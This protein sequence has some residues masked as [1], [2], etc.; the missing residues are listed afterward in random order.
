MATQDDDAAIPVISDLVTLIVTTSPTPSAP[1]TDLISDILGSFRL[2][3]P[4]LL[5]CR[6][7]VVFDTYDRIG[8]CMRLKKGQVT[9]EG[10]EAVEQ[11]KANVKDLVLGAWYPET[12][13]A[14][15][16]F[17]GAQS[18]AEYGSPRLGDNHVAL[19]TRRTADGRVTF[20][21]PAARLGFG[22][23]VRSAL[24]AAETPY[25]W[26]QQHDW[27]LVRDIPLR[28][29]VGVM[30]ASEDDGDAPPVRY[31]CL[32]AV[33]MLSYATSAH[34]MP[35][36]ALRALTE[37][38]KGDFLPPHTSASDDNNGD[39]DDAASAVPLTPLFFW[40][41]KPHVASAAHYL[42]RVFPSRLAIARGD[43]IEDSIGQRART[44]MK[45][46]NWAKWACWL[47]YPGGGREV[48]LQHRHGRRWRG[49]EAE[50]RTRAL[51]E[52]RKVAGRRRTNHPSSSPTAAA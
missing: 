39:G 38:L 30:Q 18:L 22:L 11:Y 32:P 43:F 7:V 1:S 50:A 47:Y 34:V 2:H 42:A 28:S 6:V 23:A 52:G 3:C 48:C 46:G 49:V 16:V 14:S 17:A 9:P 15:H 45:Q 44:Q 31:V 13:P 41:D 19:S 10:A 25:V 33:R 12:E 40:H 20:I 29:L 21:E 51:F 36:P 4:S 5:S 27:P 26:V 8:D 24:R 37:R 35:F